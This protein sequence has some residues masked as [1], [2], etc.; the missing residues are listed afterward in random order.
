MRRA[1]SAGTP[2]SSQDPRTARIAQK[3][4]G[5]AER[6]EIIGALIEYPSLLG[7]PDVQA[8]MDLLEG[9]AVLVV[10]AL[11]SALTEQKTLDTAS[12]LAQIP[13]AIQAFAHGRLAAPRHESEGAAKDH[14][15]DNAHKL[16][17]LFLSRE[18]DGLARDV[19]R[20]AGDSEA[21]TNLLREALERARQKHNLR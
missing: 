15:L 9:P 13:I 7:A 10:S 1:D 4:A 14:L 8:E 16:R 19:E 3:T 11:R 12:F 20:A 2:E 5:S 18:T 6:R 17:R 21:E